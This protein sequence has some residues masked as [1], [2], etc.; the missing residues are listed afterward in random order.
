[1]LQKIKKSLIRLGLMFSILI[2]EII[3]VQALIHIYVIHKNPPHRNWFKPSTYSQLFTTSKTNVLA[4]Y[5]SSFEPLSICRNIEIDPNSIISLTITDDGESKK[6]GS[7]G[8]AISLKFCGDIRGCCNPFSRF[9]ARF[10]RNLESLNL[11]GIKLSEE[12]IEDLFE[13]LKE[14][15]HFK[16]ITFVDSNFSYDQLRKY[17]TQCIPKAKLSYSWA[18]R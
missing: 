8:L 5:I 12:H 3:Q 10:P 18:G 11:I 9:K 14:C 16:N 17:A 7:L 6:L 15:K 13:D 1:M 4:L 2:F